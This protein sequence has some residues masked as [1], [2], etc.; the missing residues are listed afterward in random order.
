[1]FSLSHLAVFS[2]LRV[3]CRQ[4]QCELLHLLTQVQD[5]ALRGAAGL[6]GLR[7]GE[8]LPSRSLILD[9][10]VYAHLK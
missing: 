9:F 1:M 7:P 2:S 6:P 8:Q 3:V 4:L 10:I 5:K